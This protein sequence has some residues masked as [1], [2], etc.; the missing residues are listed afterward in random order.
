MSAQRRNKNRPRA[1]RTGQTKNRE[2]REGEFLDL[3]LVKDLE[4]KWQTNFRLISK[5][6]SKPELI[7]RINIGEP[8][9]GDPRISE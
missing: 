4:P 5:L 8:G 1:T 2:R 6:R 9:R 3:D 7:E